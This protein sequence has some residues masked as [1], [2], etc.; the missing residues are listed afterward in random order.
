MSQF[1]ATIGLKVE[2]SK[3]D[4]AIRGIESGLNRLERATSDQLNLDKRI[5][6][7]KRQL[8]GLEGDAATAARRRLDTLRNQR[9]ELAL[10]TREL[11]SQ[12]AAQNRINSVVRRRRR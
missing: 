4:R 12:L 6:G 7:V 5:L 10:Q 9:S 3:V 1:D 2:S 11:R 8:Q